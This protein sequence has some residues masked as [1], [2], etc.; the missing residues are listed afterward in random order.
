MKIKQNI[1]I[2]L[3]GLFLLVSCQR[4]QEHL[5]SESPAQRTQNGISAL[6]KILTSSENGW[7]MIYFPNVDKN[8]FSDINFNV[9]SHESSLLFLGN[10]TGFGGYTF[11]VKFSENGTLEMKSDI[12]QEARNNSVFSDY[13]ITLVSGVQLSFITKNYIHGLVNPSFLGASDFIYSHTDNDG[14]LVFK[15]T[16]HSTEDSEYIV[17]EKIKNGTDWQMQIDNIAEQKTLFE[18]W[19][20]P[21]LTIKNNAEEVVFQSNYARGDY[22]NH[23]SRYAL[24]IKDHEPN[25]FSPVYFS[26]VGSGYTYTENGMLFYAGLK[27]NDEVR[28]TDFKRSGDKFTATVNGYTAEITQQ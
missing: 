9:Y 27:Y 4:E 12:S 13:G 3:S 16:T 10:E 26:G 8:K 2:V 15:T 17:L 22:F 11:W 1:F 18:S 28:F 20:K 23:N 19:Q 6:K 21:I 25:S 14:K 24:F 7:K 5:F